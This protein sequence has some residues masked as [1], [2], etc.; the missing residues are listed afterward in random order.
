MRP[1]MRAYW[2][3]LSIVLPHFAVPYF[4]GIARRRG[5][6]ELDV[7]DQLV[8][9]W[10]EG[11]VALHGGCAEDLA[12]ARCLADPHPDAAV[13][14]EE[15][16]DEADHQQGRAHPDEVHSRVMGHDQAGELAGALEG[17]VQTG[18]G[19]RLALVHDLGTERVFLSGLVDF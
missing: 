13:W 6:G 12:A 15:D 11:E 14:E 16:E 9:L 8:E 19:R 1:A 3:K 17:V 10:F 4:L 5:V 2:D 18:D 7:G